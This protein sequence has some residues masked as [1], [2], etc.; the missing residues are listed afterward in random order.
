VH[1]WRTTSGYALERLPA[2]RK[3]FEIQKGVDFWWDFQ[4]VARV[5]AHD[6]TAKRGLRVTSPAGATTGAARAPHSPKTARMEQ[7]ARSAIAKP[8]KF[9]WKPWK[10]SAT[11]TDPVMLSF[12]LQ[13][14]SRLVQ[15]GNLFHDVMHDGLRAWV[16]EQAQQTSRS[17]SD[18]AGGGGHAGASSSIQLLQYKKFAFS[19]L[20]Q[21]VLPHFAADVKHVYTNLLRD[22]RCQGPRR[23][24][25]LLSSIEVEVKNPCSVRHIMEGLREGLST[26]V[27][28]AFGF[29]RSAKELW[30]AVGVVMDAVFFLEN[31][32]LPKQRAHAAKQ[33]EMFAEDEYA[34]FRNL[35]L[36][37]WGRFRAA[38]VRLA[39]AAKVGDRVM[40]P[41]VWETKDQDEDV[42][43][44]PP[45][46]D[47]L[48]S[49][50]ADSLARWEIQRGE[51][52]SNFNG[53]VNPESLLKAWKSLERKKESEVENEQFVNRE[54]TVKQIPLADRAK[55]L[56]HEG[57][58]VSIHREGGGDLLHIRLDTS[59]AKLS[60]RLV[61]VRAS[62]VR[63]V[64]QK[65]MQRTGTGAP[66]GLDDQ[67][68]EEV[69]AGSS[70]INLSL[71]RKGLVMVQAELTRNQPQTL[72]AEDLP[73]AE[74]RVA[75]EH[76]N[77]WLLLGRDDPG[78]H[79]Q[80]FERGAPDRSV[81][82][83]LFPVELMLRSKKE[84][85]AIM[86]KWTPEVMPG[87]A[88]G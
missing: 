76:P 49:K 20:I 7:D 41:G 30:E 4:E 66:R 85:A 3:D 65:Q 78:S 74:R 67:E 26:F 87:G 75:G 64:K 79:D 53:E 21:P 58:I 57:T 9:S 70:E 55:I 31:D 6:V 86:R 62:N 34:K 24:K 22:T 63:F 83:E 59:R 18:D 40:V 60:N 50:M 47:D 61:S 39:M 13:T 35:E 69:V 68:D 12:L 32:F 46:P 17:R 84:G 28:P 44:E 27:G 15:Y 29:P 23:L 33:W 42:G 51:E 37:F 81:M 45:R 38:V 71:L 16:Q 54:Q 72:A 36:Y 8:A 56:E 82:A 88:D 10:Y 5:L 43:Q 52:G 25:L 19:N 1:A 77:S 11:V 48:A 80:W 73:E 2:C 14:G